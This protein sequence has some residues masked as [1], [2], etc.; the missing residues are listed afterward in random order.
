MMSHVLQGSRRRTGAPEAHSPGCSTVMPASDYAVSHASRHT[1]FPYAVE[2]RNAK[3]RPVDYYHTLAGAE[4]A[5]RMLNAGTCTVEP[6]RPVG[7]RIVPMPAF[8]T[9]RSNGGDPF[10]EERIQGAHMARCA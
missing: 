1:G 7:C 4:Y 3:G 9:G 5:A 6:H 2:H 10:T 8:T